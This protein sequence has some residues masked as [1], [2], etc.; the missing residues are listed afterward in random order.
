MA[1]MPRATA[2]ALVPFIGTF[3]A[4]RG[5]SEKEAAAWVDEQ[6]S[7]AERGE[8]YFACTQ[9]CFTARKPLQPG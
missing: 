4:G 3:V 9:L 7:L 8:F 1:P 6:R 2:S 5:V